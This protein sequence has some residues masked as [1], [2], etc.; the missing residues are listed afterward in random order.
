MD[1]AEYLAAV[2]ANNYVGKAVGTAEAALIPVL[3]EMYAA[4]PD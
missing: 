4:S 3:A 1:S 2:A